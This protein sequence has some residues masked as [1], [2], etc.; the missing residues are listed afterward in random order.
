MSRSF[1]EKSLRIQK[2]IRNNP[3]MTDD[4]IAKKIGMDNKVGRERVKKERSK[5]GKI[6]YIGES[7]IGDIDN[8][9]Y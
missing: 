7:N 9:C 1:N 5:S 4:Q 3:E 6:G 2:I 8:Q